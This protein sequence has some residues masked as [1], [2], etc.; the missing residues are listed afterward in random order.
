MDSYQL[1]TTLIWKHFLHLQHLPP[2]TKQ[3]SGKVQIPALCR[4]T[5]MARKTWL[6]QQHTAALSTHTHY[7]FYS[8]CSKLWPKS[9]VLFSAAW[10]RKPSTPQG[11]ICCQWKE[12]QELLQVQCSGDPDLHCFGGKL[13]KKQQSE[14]P[15]QPCPPQTTTTASSECNWFYRFSHHVGQ[16]YSQGQKKKAF[17]IRSISLKGRTIWRYFLL[18]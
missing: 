17:C 10:K 16:M 4:S 2:D 18:K 6:Q 12:W 14:M 1:L 13:K 8:A 7:A 11:L 3:I 9:L 15:S 5:A